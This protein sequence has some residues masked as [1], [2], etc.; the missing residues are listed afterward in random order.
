MDQDLY[1]RAKKRANQKSYM[2]E[3]YGAARPLY[4]ET[5]RSGIGIGA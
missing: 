3:A 4:L 2:H 1:N 5:D